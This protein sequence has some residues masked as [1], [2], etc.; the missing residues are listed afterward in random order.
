MLP[1]NSVPVVSVIIVNWN[2]LALSRTCIDSVRAN[3]SDISHEI[4]VVDNASTD[5]SVAW[6]REQSPEIVLITNAV[7]VGFA[8]ANNQGIAACRGEFALLLNS[9]AQLQEGTLERLLA[10]MRQEPRAG[11]AA[12]MLVNPDGSF[13]AGPNDE[14]TL[15]NETLLA[16]GLARLARGGYYPG[17]AADAPRGNYAW[18]GGT[19]LFMRRTA[20]EQAGLLDP[21]YFM[22]TEEADWCWRARKAG[23]LL[24]YEPAA[25]TIHLGAGSSRQ[26]PAK[27][28]AAL[29]RSKIIFFQKNRPR[30]QAIILRFIVMATA[31]AKAA[32][33]DAAARLSKV[34]AQRWHERAASFRLVVDA[35]KTVPA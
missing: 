9:D 26:V 1:S 16:L 31:A 13:Q 25:R 20:W 29:Y 30:R 27:M 33:Y 15:V 17:Y 18:L 6:L 11:A 8:S 35:V 21:D 5:G 19:C 28:R 3:A 23:W 12:P 2:T 14:L 10:V 24:I 22:Y 32:V 7:N 4:I 34:R